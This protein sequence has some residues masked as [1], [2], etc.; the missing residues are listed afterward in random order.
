MIAEVLV[1]VVA[2]K[3]IV[4]V[5]SVKI[6]GLKSV[7]SWGITRS[8]INEGLEPFLA[9]SGFPE[10]HCLVSTARDQGLSIRA[11]RYATIWSRALLTR[12]CPSGRVW[13]R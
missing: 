10:L 11:P 6:F 8:T 3:K 4:K 13:Q 5:G 1:G 2:S 12:E 9:R 7:A